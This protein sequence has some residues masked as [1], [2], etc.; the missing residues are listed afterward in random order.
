MKKISIIVPV[1]NEE[2]YIRSVI[3]TVVKAKVKGFTKEI[4]IVCDGS[5]DKTA[6]ILKKLGK[7]YIKKSNLSK[8]KIIYN[9][10][11]LGKGSALK[12]GMKYVTGDI[13]ITQDA[14]LE[15]NPIEYERLLKPFKQ[16]Q[17]TVVFGSRTL[18][19]IKYHNNYSTF[20][21]YLGGQILTYFVNILYGTRLTDQ[22]TGYKLFRASLIPLLISEKSENGFAFEVVMTAVLVKN[23]N[24]IVEVPITYKPRQIKEGKKINFTDFIKSVYTAIKYKFN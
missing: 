21:F 8:L 24:W 22:P 11:N 18:G 17:V 2:N 7:E 15:Y 3:K 16:K 10:K 5:T 13:V 23:G 9:K 4:I 12:Q 20:L 1:Y 19:R 14:D 6:Q